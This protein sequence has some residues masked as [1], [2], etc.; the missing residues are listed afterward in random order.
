M[1]DWLTFF[2]RFLPE[3]IKGA[4]VTLELTAVG[5][6]I[7]FVLGLGI[8]AGKGIWTKMVALPGDWLY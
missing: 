8:S 4:G 5:L 2:Q 1:S 3:F 6:V 7:G